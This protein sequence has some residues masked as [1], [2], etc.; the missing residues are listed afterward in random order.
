MSDKKKADQP[1]QT[2]KNL[3]FWNS[4]GTTMPSKT[5]P[6]KS[7]NK[8]LTSV[9]PYYTIMKATAA[10]G[11][12][13]VNW[14]YE[15]VDQQV[16]NGVWFSKIRLWYKSKLLVPGAKGIAEVTHWG[17]TNMF[18]SNGT[19]SDDAPKSSITDGVVKCLSLLGFS[20]DVFMGMYDNPEY[21]RDLKRQEEARNK[22]KAGN[23]PQPQAAPQQQHPET[24]QSQPQQPQQQSEIAQ[25]A[26]PQQQPPTPPPGIA[27]ADLPTID[28][29]E[30]VEFADG[31]GALYWEAKD[32][33]SGSRA[34]YDKK[35]FIQAAG[36]R[37]SP[38]KKWLAP[39][40]Q[41]Q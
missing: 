13:G 4:V 8:D 39:I 38:L 31:T 6:Y 32:A 37:W 29:I 9:N 40:Q 2:E 10:F 36:F 24:S 11:P 22:K 41:T 15:E 26:S 25:E 3:M 14:G 7:G 35:D 33:K 20:A 23:Q 16:W 28:G 1:S 12:I 27:E 21:V 17:G 34:T 19:P 5:S 30:F 18:K